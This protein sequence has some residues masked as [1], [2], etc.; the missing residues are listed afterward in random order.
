MSARCAAGAG[1]CVLALACDP[2]LPGDVAGTFNVHVTL[3]ENTCGAGAVFTNDQREYSVELRTDETH[4]RAYWHVPKVQPLTGSL[5]PGDSFVFRM[6]SVVATQAGDAGA[7]PCSLVQA[8]E[9]AGSFLREDAGTDGADD[10]LDAESARAADTADGGVVSASVAEPTSDAPL[11][12]RHT[13]TISAAQ[14]SDC[15]V[16]IAP[17]GPFTL[18]PCTLRYDLVG[19]RRG[20]L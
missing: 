7:L 6:E 12:A 4:Q 18:L 8:E 10:A 9:L 5:A 16:A 1:L 2:Q 19:T 15:S 11:A 20:P 14:G 13:L 3:R 17:K